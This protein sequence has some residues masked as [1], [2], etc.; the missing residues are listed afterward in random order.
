METGRTINREPAVPLLPSARN[1]GAATPPSHRPSWGMDGEVCS[2]PN[3]EYSIACLPSPINEIQICKPSK[4]WEEKRGMRSAIFFP[5]FS[6]RLVICWHWLWQ[7]TD[8]YSIRHNEGS[9]CRASPPQLD[10]SCSQV[11]EPTV[12]KW[13][14]LGTPATENQSRMNSDFNLPGVI[15][16]HQTEEAARLYLSHHYLRRATGNFLSSS[17]TLTFG[18]HNQYFKLTSLNY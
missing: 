17:R 15:F 9:R 8:G 1:H 18:S 2:T 7:K 10:W 6:N 13:V 11:R 12:F 14:Q 16:K 4:T 5:C 3:P